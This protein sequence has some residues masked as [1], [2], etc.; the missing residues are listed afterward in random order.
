[1]RLRSI[2]A[3]GAVLLCSTVA[4]AQAYLAPLSNGYG[5]FDYSD[6]LMRA[7]K[8]EVVHKYHFDEGVRSLQRG[9]NSSVWADLNYVL[10]AFPNHHEA[11]EAMARLLR[12]RDKPMSR[13]LYDARYRGM[14]P[15]V[16][17]RAYFEHAMRFAPHDGVVRLLYGIDLHLA[18]EPEAAAARYLEARELGVDSADLWYNLGLARLAL[19]DGEGAL[20]AA[21]R[22]YALGHPLPGLRRKLARAG[23]WPA[24]TAG[25]GDD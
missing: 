8:L 24:A 17:S 20:A 3:A 19:G 21:R 1:M 5:P 25:T 23:L 7:T 9:M 12:L 16:E 22:A 2:G 14:P 11:L 6:P 10:R 13:A 18:G 4:A 15:E